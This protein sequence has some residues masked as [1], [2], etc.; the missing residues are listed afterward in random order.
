MG[1]GDEMVQVELKTEAAREAGSRSQMYRLLAQGFAFPV[2]A[3]YEEVRSGLYLSQVQAA[4]KGLPYS[5]EVSGQL[6]K[7]AGVSYDDFQSTHIA[8]FEVGGPD[9]APVPL[10]EGHY[11]GGLLRDMEEVLRL[12]HHFGLSYK[13]GFRP[14]HLQTELEFMHA[15]TFGEAASDGDV[16]TYRAAE[17][18]FLQYHLQDLAGR[19]ATGLKDRSAPLYPELGQLLQDLVQKD[20]AALA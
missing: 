20:L 16:S 15:L 12:Y 14:D 17:R 1:R 13:G 3:F 2:P 11:G 6:G 7:G 9:G 19:V 8:Q 18:D 4:A 5:L 10:Y